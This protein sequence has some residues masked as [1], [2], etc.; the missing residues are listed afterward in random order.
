MSY[1]TFL[2]F[3]Q[4][5]LG[6]ALSSTATSLTVSSTTGLPSSLA[7]G[8]F[9]PMTLT[10]ASS[11][12]SAYEIVYVTGI[13]G[14]SLTVTRGEEG[15]SALN[16]NTGDILYS[17]NTAETTGTSMGSPSTDFQ[18]NTLTASGLITANDGIDATGN[19]TVS[20]LVITSGIST[21]TV[22]NVKYYGAT[23]NGTTDDTTAIQNAINAAVSAGTY[24]I[25]FPAGNYLTSSQLTVNFPNNTNPYHIN[26]VGDGQEASNIISNPS[27]SANCLVVNLYNQYQSI[28]IENISVFSNT[29]NGDSVNAIDIVQNST[30]ITNPANSSLSILRNI[31]IRG[32][33]GFTGSNYFQYG[34]AIHGASNFNIVSTDITMNNNSSTTGIYIE[35]PSSSYDVPVVFNLIGVTVNYC[36]NGL[37]VGPNTQG[38]TINS[39]NFVGNTYGIVVPSTASGVNQ[40]SIF[41]SSFNNNITNIEFNNSVSGGMIIGNIFYIHPSGFGVDTNGSITFIGSII[42]NTFFATTTPSS[43]TA[44]ALSSTGPL[45]ITGNVIQNQTNGISLGSTTSLINVQGNSYQGVGSNV[46]NSGTN[47]TV[48]V[49]TD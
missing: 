26:I 48:G 22:I 44:I 42:G 1:A 17:T 16:W 28:N 49:A 32:S 34:I 18:T 38:V 24:T 11:P 19:I 5:T 13:S 41:N 8:Q 3:Y 7:S 23:G 37:V 35:G 40:L 10:P 33:N 12:G 46:T 21:E 29:S 31:T 30:T 43:Q 2:N 47:N 25:Y 9:I 6:A 36:Q 15:T 39:S 20:D 45:Q 14:S 27:A 4:T